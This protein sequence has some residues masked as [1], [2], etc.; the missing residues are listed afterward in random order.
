MTG[1]FVNKTIYDLES[2]AQ[3]NADDLILVGK[4]DGSGLIAAKA[5]RL[6]SLNP[7]GPTGPQGATGPAG[8]TGPTGSGSGGG[9]SEVTHSE[10]LDFIDTNDLVPGGYY[11]ITD[12]RTCYDQPDFDYNGD[13]ITSGNY[14]TSDVHPII[15][16]AISENELAVEA[17]QPDYPN[18]TIKYDTSWVETEVTGGTAYGRIIERIDSSGNRTDYDHRNIKFKRYYSYTLDSRISGFVQ[19]INGQNVTGFQTSFDTDLT[20]GDIVFIPT[21]NSQA[22]GFYKVT[23]INSPTSIEVEGHNYYSYNFSPDPGVYIWKCE[24]SKQNVSGEASSISLFAMNGTVQPGDSLFGASSIYFTNCYPGLFVMVADTIDITSFNI[25]GN[26]GADGSGLIDV[27]EYST[28]VGGNN[29]KAYIKRISDAGDPSV[30]HIIIVNTDGTGITHNYSTDTDDDFDEVTDLS[31]NGVTQIH[32]LLTG[33]RNGVAITDV[34]ADN[35]VEAYLGQVDGNNI[36]TILTNLNANYETITGVLP[37]RNP[38][39]PGSL[40]YFNDSGNND[41]DDGGN[42]MYDGGNILNT[43]LA[44]D[45]P[46]THTQMGVY[47]SFD[48]RQS[49]VI[50]NTEFKEMGTFEVVDAKNTYIGDYSRYYDD[51]YGE[52][53]ILANNVF[54]RFT[55]SRDCISNYVGEGCRNNTFAG[56]F[57][58]NNLVGNINQNIFYRDFYQNSVLNSFYNNISFTDD[59]YNNEIGSE[60]ND[61][62]ITNEFY[63]N[64][65][66]NNFNNNLFFDNFQNNAIGN[67][68]QNNIFTDNFYKNQVQNGYNNNKSYATTYG[69]KIGNGYNNNTIY[70][71]FRDNQIL[72]YFAGNTIG[73]SNLINSFYFDKNKI[74]TNFENNSIAGYFYNNN[75]SNYFENNLMGDQIAYNTIGSNFQNNNVGDG[76]G[77]GFS[78]SQGNLIGNYFNN[79]TIGEYFYN[80]TIADGFSSNT[81]VD[82]FQFN[83]VKCPL[84]ST[85]FTSATHVYGYYNCTLF[86]NAISASRLSYYDSDDVLTITDINL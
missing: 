27:Y 64:D 17:Y 57:S 44:S 52:T 9:Y 10:L 67:Q 45:I 83:D 30:N 56:D 12:F 78:T 60:F 61:N 8:I 81:V 79:N 59:F 28:V 84:S 75:I 73:S 43:N 6:A 50:D 66:G 19:E 39:V 26:L 55:S 35:L 86:L 72:D 42:D 2:P 24:L 11:A 18:D 4:S 34:E 29:Y 22:R 65:V 14:K 63:R 13:A 47:N 76:F 82:N 5:S 70:N 58:N 46:Y 7:V 71:S 3:I 41:I 38:A 48:Y 54:G 36:N 21:P 32:Y 74:G 40:Y 31:T 85:N 69:N 49:N 20:V 62:I 15:V 37:E 16:F 68:F 53:F 25:S 80:N 77:F 23:A 1:N 33:L 51:W